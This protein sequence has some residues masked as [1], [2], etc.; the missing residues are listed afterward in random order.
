[1]MKKLE[2][3]LVKED[4]FSPKSQLMFKTIV[5]LYEDDK[6][7]GVGPYGKAKIAAEEVCLEFREKNKCINSTIN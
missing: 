1:M 7:D 2:Q 5:D 4:F 3:Y 6:L